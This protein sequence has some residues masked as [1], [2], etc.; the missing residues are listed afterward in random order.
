M[1]RAAANWLAAQTPAANV[2]VVGGGTLVDVVREWDHAYELSASGAHWLAIRGMSLTAE[3]AASLLPDA[4]RVDDVSQIQRDVGGPLQVFACERFLREEHDGALP[5]GWHV[6]SDSIAARVAQA[7]AAG[8]LVLLKS[9]LPA[10]AG[11][12]DVATA[13]AK[14]AGFVDDYFDVAA[15]GLAVRIVNL[16]D[17]DFAESAW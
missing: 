17:A 9:A 15:Q 6:T 5:H 2:L 8:E 1:A 3:L 11:S 4:R 13:R 7:L 12:S 10:E 14:Q 16:R